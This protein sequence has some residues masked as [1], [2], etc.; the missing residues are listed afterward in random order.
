ML[1]ALYASG[2]VVTMTV[3]ASVTTVLRRSADSTLAV[4]A[5]LVLVSALVW[6]LLWVACVQVVLL[7]SLAKGMGAVGAHTARAYTADAAKGSTAHD[8]PAVA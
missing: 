7:L 6:P 4:S 1:A 8:L 5:L 2:F 3:M